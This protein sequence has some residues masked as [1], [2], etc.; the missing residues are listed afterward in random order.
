MRK[1]YFEVHI[2]EMACGYLDNRTYHFFN[3]KALEDEIKDIIMNY[4]ENYNEPI[5]ISIFYFDEIEI[6]GQ[7]IKQDVK[8][9]FEWHK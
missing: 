7:L 8:K 5:S 6:F 2:L 9:V 3:K 4:E 1:Q